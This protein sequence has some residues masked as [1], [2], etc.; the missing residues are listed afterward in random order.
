MNIIHIRRGMF[1][2]NIACSRERRIADGPPEKS[3]RARANALAKWH[4]ASSAAPLLPKRLADQPLISRN[5]RSLL[6]FT[7]Y[8]IAPREPPLPSCETRWH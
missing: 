1:S 4:L 3:M 2:K 6:Y 5:A 8:G 7:R